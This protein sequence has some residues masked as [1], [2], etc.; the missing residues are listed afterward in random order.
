MAENI[1]YAENVEDDEDDGED[2]GDKQDAESWRN[3]DERCKSD[4]VMRCNLIE[5]VCCR[6][7]PPRVPERLLADNSSL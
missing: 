6:K 4:A 5:Q 7:Y 2:H 3:E 1:G